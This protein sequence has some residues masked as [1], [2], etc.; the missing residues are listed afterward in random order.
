[1]S[2][3]NI[4]YNN[5]KNNIKV[6]TMFFISMIFSVVILSNFLI[7]MDGE[8]MKVLGDMNEEYSKLILQVITV[9][10]VIFMFFFI[11]Y[12]SNIFLRNRKK[13]IGIYA[14]MGLDSSVIGKIYFIEM[15]LIGVSASIIGTIIGVVLSKFF[16]IIVFKIADFNIDVKFSVSLNSIIYTIAIFMC[17][18]LF[19]SIK[20][21]ISI[22]RSK[23][24]DLL[25]AS[26][27]Q[28]RMPKVNFLI[29]VIAIISLIL[30]GYGYYLVSKQA[31]DAFKTLILV[32]IGTYG[33]FGAVFPIVFNFL[34]NRKSILYKGSNIITINNLAYRLK[35]NYTVYATIAILTATTT[36]VL[37]TAFSM[38]TTYENSLKNINLYSL[39]ISS[40]DEFNSEEIADKLKEVGEEKH[41]LKTKVLKVNSTLKNVPE[42]Q[43]D[44]YIV[45]SYD[46]LSNILKANGDE[47]ELSKFNEEM[48][49]GNNVIYIERPGTLMSLISNIKDITLNDVKFNVSESTRIRVFGEAL[50]YS[51]IVVNNDEY[52]KLKETATEINFYGIKIENEENIINVIDKI[53]K[54]LNLET[55]HGFYGQFELKTIEWVKFVYAIGGFL[56]LVMALAEASIIYIKIYSDANEDKQKYKTLLSIGASKKDIS[57]SISRE[58][59]L[60]YFIPLVVGAIH[61]YFAI[62][63]LADF[64]KENLN[65]V[66]LLSLVICIA[67]FIVNCIISI[68]G[69]KK[70]IGIKKN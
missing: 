46:N 50:N 6:Y 68:I 66:Y 43:N 7:M 5:F 48:V 65:F 35:K 11:W 8:A 17:I 70:I 24:V 52:E 1:M 16:Q 21:F 58:V 26:K 3:F 30:I 34:I 37:G 20:G 33:L 55:T 19:M 42:Y 39:A 44:E 40:T 56:F 57:K 9:I 67:I 4:A 2:V 10:L 69:F 18:F 62:N 25:N 47:K 60:F 41:S 59:A 29:Y 13:E 31:T 14:F 64:M 32:C 61:S 22:V 23:I 49:Q 36:T 27:K 54:N 15:M 28:E 38:K 51:T 63:A 12:A 53:G 45:V